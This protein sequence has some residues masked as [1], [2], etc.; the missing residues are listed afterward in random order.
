MQKF[1]GAPFALG[2][3]LRNCQNWKKL[4]KVAKS[5]KDSMQNPTLVILNLH[6]RNKTVRVQCTCAIENADFVCRG[7]TTVNLHR[8]I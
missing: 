7:N 5:M 3:G 6:I 2:D 4:E 8:I 1:S